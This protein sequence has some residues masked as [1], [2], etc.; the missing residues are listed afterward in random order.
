MAGQFG[1]WWL[2][3][4][5]SCQVALGAPARY[6]A[7]LEG[8]YRRQRGSWRLQMGVES[9]KASLMHRVLDDSTT[10]CAT[11]YSIFKAAS[12]GRWCLP[13]AISLT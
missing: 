10:D 3:G 13:S 5:R 4:W 8:T 9:T 2:G 1:I 7:A 11:V 12:C 6:P